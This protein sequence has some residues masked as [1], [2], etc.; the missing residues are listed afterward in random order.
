MVS[1]RGEQL[2]HDPSLGG[3]EDAPLY[4]E[5]GQGGEAAAEPA[6]VALLAKDVGRE[7]LFGEAAQESL[8]VLLLPVVGK[9][10]G[11]A[12]VLG[13]AKLLGKSLLRDV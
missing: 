12:G 3:G 1:R 7:E 9:A 11:A 4:D 8:L 13:L 5:G 6:L 10:E 2:E